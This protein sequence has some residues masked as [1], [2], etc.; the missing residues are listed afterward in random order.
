MDYRQAYEA[1][2]SDEVIDE[3]TKEDLLALDSEDEIQDRFYKTLEFGTAGMRGKM[4]AGPNRMNIYTIGKVSQAF[5]QVLK[6][7]GE[8]RPFVI[9]YDVRHG[10][11]EFAAY[12]ARVFASNGIRV[13]LSEDILATPITSYAIRQVGAGGGVIITASHNPSDYSGYKAYGANGGQILDDLVG[14]I[15]EV[16]ENLTYGDIKAGD[17]DDLMARGMISYLPDELYGSYI[18]DV[19]AKALTEDIDKD[20]KIVYS[21]FNGTGRKPVLQVLK[22]R[23]FENIYLVKDQ[24]MPDP[25]FSGISYPNPEEPEV[26]AKAMDL[27]RK[28]GADILM[29]TDPDADRLGLMVWDGDSYRYLTG[30]ETGVLLTS[31]IFARM[32]ENGTLGAKPAF[33]T[34]V[35]TGDMAKEIAGSYGA[36]VYVTLT[37]FKNIAHVMEGLGPRG[38]DFVF[39]FEEAIGYLY[40]DSIRDKDGISASMVISEMA[41][42]YKKRGL[43][44]VQVL[45][46]LYEDY[47]YYANKQF[48]TYV[49]GI[50]GQERVE[51]IMDSFRKDPIKDLGGL[52][53][54]RSIDYLYDDT[55]LAESNVLKY[56]YGKSW[57]VARPSGTEPKLRFYINAFGQSRDQARLI[58]EEAE[59]KIKKRL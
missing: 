59:E 36:E 6:D 37:G 33:I 19:L 30:N 57:F 11:K 1:W 26:F 22:R 42:Y 51:E 58:L 49:E 23:G 18:E 31:Y 7:R 4:G 50:H 9:A 46:G 47:G 13:Y 28:I 45:E 14:A 39:A 38:E 17:F 52:A 43:N 2:L 44:L 21:P 25:N 8:D 12:T 54:E 24:E 5:A 15:M 56:F 53:L 34:T 27:G 20:L 35:V 29:G 32:K 41:G 3:Q 40:G 10:S 48:Y 55:G 16:V